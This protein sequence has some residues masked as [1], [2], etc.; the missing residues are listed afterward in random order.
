[1]SCLSHPIFTALLFLLWEP[2]TSV[3][4][5]ERWVDALRLVPIYIGV[6]PETDETVQAVLSWIRSEANSVH[7]LI[8]RGTTFEFTF[9][10]L[11]GDHSLLRKVNFCYFIL[12][13]IKNTSKGMSN[14]G[15]TAERR[16]EFC[17]ASFKDRS[18]LWSYAKLRLCCCKTLESLV[19]MWADPQIRHSSGLK[20]MPP[21][22]LGDSLEV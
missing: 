21:P 12:N 14:L 22:L 6:R 1:M 13:N 9:R 18:S 5:E 4:T 17:D 20:D 3:A 8:W 19:Q 10:L 15:G 16:C 11:T 2:E 7:N